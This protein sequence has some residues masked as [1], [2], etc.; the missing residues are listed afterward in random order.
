MILSCWLGFKRGNITRGTPLNFHKQERGSLVLRINSRKGFGQNQAT[1]S[2]ESLTEGSFHQLL[3]GMPAQE[4]TE[5]VQVLL[6]SYSCVFQT[7][8]TTKSSDLIEITTTHLPGAEP[9]LLQSPRD[10]RHHVFIPDFRA[11]MLR[12]VSR[13]D[14]NV[15][16]L[17]SGLV[18]L[19]Q[20]VTILGIHCNEATSASVVLDKADLRTLFGA[21]GT[22]KSEKKTS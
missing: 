13:V 15:G 18:L 16:L 5:I 8:W 14:R 4:Q 19:D 22:W 20:H 9:N 12:S 1:N 3:A 11:R 6:L 10:Y 21:F 17:I 7:L 2:N